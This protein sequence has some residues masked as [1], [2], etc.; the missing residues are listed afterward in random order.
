MMTTDAI[1]RRLNFKVKMDRRTLGIT[2]AGAVASCSRPNKESRTPELKPQPFGKAADGT[3]VDMYKL[4]KDNGMEI[5]IITYG[6][7][8]QSLRVPDAKGKITDLVLGFD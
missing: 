8:V 1:W 4:R 2:I 5:A 3:P 7:I 6:G